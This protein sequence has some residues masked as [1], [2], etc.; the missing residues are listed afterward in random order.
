MKTETCVRTVKFCSMHFLKF[1][2][3]KITTF[4]FLNSTL[5][6]LW[7]EFN[8]IMSGVSVKI[9]VKGVSIVVAKLVKKYSLTCVSS[10]LNYN[11]MC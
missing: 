11:L 2:N 7:A 3:S 5:R 4:E 9:V 8:F 10:L 6:S 1:P